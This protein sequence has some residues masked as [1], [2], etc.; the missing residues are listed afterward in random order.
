MQWGGI[1]QTGLA[2]IKR[3]ESCKL[4][5]YPDDKGVPTLGYGHTRGVKLGDV[6]TQAQADAWLAQDCAW[7]WQA[8]MQ[9]VTAPLNDN[10]AGA[11]LSFVFNLGEP[12]WLTTS[13]LHDLNA[14]NYAAVPADMMK[15]NKETRN[16]VL[17]V[18]V[19]LTNR[20]VAETRLWSTPAAA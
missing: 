9:H 3:L 6:C 20:R 11:L 7:A 5:A 12:H 19:G 14:G 10:Q 13:A 2:L 18:D 1:P 15:W 16:G 17:V 4:A 8:I